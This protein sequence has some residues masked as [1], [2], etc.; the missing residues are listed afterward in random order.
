MDLLVTVLVAGADPAAG[1]L[2]SAY[3]GGV[4]AR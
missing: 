2:R 3:F 1:L 4:T